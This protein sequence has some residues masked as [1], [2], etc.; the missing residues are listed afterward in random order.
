MPPPS[1]SNPHPAEAR[2]LQ[3]LIAVLA[4]LPVSAGVAGIVG[5]P[6][7]LGVEPPWPADLDSHLRFLSGV[8]LVVG[9]AWWSCIP[10]IAEKTGRL[11][12]LALMTFAGGL[13]RL[14]SVGL[15]GWPSAGHVAGLSM[16]LVVVPALTLWHARIASRI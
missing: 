12:L 14:W 8:F 9:L 1:R 16:E 10:R 3:A 13:A 7:F 11:R 5:G 6:R 15:A 2:I 4:L